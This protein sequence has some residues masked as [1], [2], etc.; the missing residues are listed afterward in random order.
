MNNNADIVRQLLALLVDQ[1][2]PVTTSK[3]EEAWITGRCYMIRTVTMTWTVRLT[4]ITPQELVLH[5]AAWI[6]DTG[7]YHLAVT[8]DALN[9]VEPVKGP[10]I[11]GRGSIVDAREWTSPLPREPK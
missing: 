6:A 1:T 8:A 10:V 9:E 4:H 3:S 2:D 11:I 5:D 7:R